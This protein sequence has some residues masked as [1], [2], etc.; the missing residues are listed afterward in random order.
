MRELESIRKKIDRVDGDILRL[1]AVRLELAKDIGAAKKRIG[2]P[3][4]DR[5]R[6]AEVLAK[7]SEKAK[8][9]G[10][11]HEDVQV[12][13]K[14]VI[15]MSRRIQGEDVHVTYLGPQGT[16]TEEAA[17]CFFSG[18]SLNLNSSIS[19]PEVFRAVEMDEFVYGLVPIENS[20]EGPVNVT[21]DLLLESCLQ[22]YG[23]V[24]LQVRHNLMAKP[25][26]DLKNVK[27]ILSH[28]QAFPQCRD[29]LTKYFPKAELRETSSTSRAVELLNEIPNAA[30][31]AS[32]LAAERYGM[33]IAARGI[34]DNPR[35][36]TRFLVLSKNDHSRTGRDKTSIIFSV[37]HLPGALHK[38][39][40][41]FSSNRV[42][43]TKIESRPAKQKLW[44]YV[45]FLDF[46][47]HRQDPLCLKL[48]EELKKETTFLKVLGSYPTWTT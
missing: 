42:N 34:Q 32:E 14:D 19:I 30:A 22:I 9:L 4:M 10:L 12:I 15:A 29:Y 17:R 20:T 27:V 39:L 44:E 45:F 7:V 35:N 21:L 43:I 48:L 18:S 36:F 1:L 3:I 38:A 2:K 6:E 16:F 41:I 24:E 46:E 13:F 25:G 33:M 5:G 11:G 47:G 23:E 26:F 40:G 31:V 37:K 28:P 8:I